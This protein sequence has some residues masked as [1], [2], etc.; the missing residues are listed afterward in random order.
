M[1][2]AGKNPMMF[3]VDKRPTKDL[4]V[5]VNDDDE[6]TEEVLPKPQIMRTPR[7]S[8]KR[9]VTF[10]EPIST[11]RMANANLE[12][13]E[14]AGYDDLDDGMEHESK[15]DKIR[16]EIANC[17]LSRKATKLQNLVNNGLGCHMT[18][19]RV[20][21]ICREV[22]NGTEKCSLHFVLY[23][24]LCSKAIIRFPDICSRK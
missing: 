9:E 11:T 17:E 24:L 12:A 21:V 14:E 10:T 2:T 19:V 20:N 6:L 7:L 22:L 16:V 13:R 15:A 5:A 23:V 18:L 4:E 8:R 3:Q 1:K